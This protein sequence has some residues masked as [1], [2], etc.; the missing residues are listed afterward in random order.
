MSAEYENANELVFVS[1]ASQM[2]LARSMDVEA[3]S[4]EYLRN[5][6]ECAADYSICQGM[7]ADCLMS[8]GQSLDLSGLNNL[9]ELPSSIAKCSNLRSLNISNTRLTSL[10]PLR[11]LSHLERVSAW[12]T[13]ISDLSPLAGM[14]SLTHLQLGGTYISDITALRELTGLRYLDVSHSRVA[15]ISPLSLCKDLR[16]LI[17]RD[18]EVYDITPIARLQ[19]LEI[20]DLSLCPV[21]P[22]MIQTGPRIKIVIREAAAVEKPKRKGLFSS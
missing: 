15:D 8:D 16:E 22:S 6:P 3:P 7:I 4:T 17:L 20:L 18:T 19:R 21:D 2:K 5:L 13:P 12:A 9:V 14:R 11:G 10:Q 1:N